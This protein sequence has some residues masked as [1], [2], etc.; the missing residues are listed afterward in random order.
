MIEH[1]TF[2]GGTPDRE[3]LQEAIRH[4]RLPSTIRQ[5]CANIT[6]MVA[7][8]ESAHFTIDRSKLGEVARRVARLTRERYPGAVVPLHSRWRHF[9]AGGIDRAAQLDARM[10]GA[11]K[12]EM[13]RT[14]ID[15]VVISVLLD[16]GA[17][18]EWGHVE[19]GGGRRY[20]RSEGLAVATFN[21]FMAGHFSSDL[22]A[23]LRVDAK[24][25]ETMDAQRLGAVFQVRDS[26]PLVGLEGRVALMRRLGAALRER[27]DVF[28][29][30]GRPGQLFD[31][32]SHAA[33]RA[34]AATPA[35][36]RTQ[37]LPVARIAAPHILRAVLKAFGG[38]WPSGQMLAGKPVGDVWFHPAAGGTGIDANRVPFHKLSQ[39]LV[40]SMVEPLQWAGLT[41]DRI[42]ELT[43]LPEYRNG[44]LLIDAG[45]IVPRKPD[46]ASQVYTP[47]DRWVVEWRALTVT[48]ID[49]VARL[50]RT[51]LNEPRLPLAAV[52]EGGTWA[53]GREIAA[54]VRPGG[55]PPVRVASDGTLF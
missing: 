4:L 19:G 12:A 3:A 40:Y 51:E 29:A 41:V 27:A 5:R 24:A 45:V 21:G 26:N 25:L 31:V 50:V 39:W 54:E 48:L 37:R 49:D 11:D 2:A 33:V 34:A 43:A 15:L 32:L 35:E 38:I 44:G 1:S 28:P 55:P 9:G 16:A 52:L 53:A 47:A 7:A 20:L 36:Q 6:A 23:P 13:A 22:R 17:G 10:A 30:P 14:R 18:P 42:D 46:Y 8:G